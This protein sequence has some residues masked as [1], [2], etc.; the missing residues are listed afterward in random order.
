MILGVILS[1]QVGLIIGYVYMGKYLETLYSLASCWLSSDKN[2][3]LPIM[4]KIYAG[5]LRIY[6]P[7]ELF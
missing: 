3:T 4:A 7:I 1:W 2:H 5:G 6:M